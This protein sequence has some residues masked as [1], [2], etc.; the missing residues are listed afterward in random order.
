MTTEI[1]ELLTVAEAAQVLRIS[2]NLTYELVHQG[3]L[4]H[5]QLGR[6]ILVP[7]RALDLWIVEEA[8]A[9]SSR[10]KN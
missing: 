3:R 7:R 8:H 2:R 1:S 6:R 10:G 5:L 9:H 4:P